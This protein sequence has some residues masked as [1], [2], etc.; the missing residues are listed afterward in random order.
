M[1]ICCKVVVG[2]WKDE[3]IQYKIV[4]WMCVCVGWVDFQD[5]LIICFGDQMN[6]VVVIDGDKVEVE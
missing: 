5:M 4:V 1:C 6:N 2:Y 3:D